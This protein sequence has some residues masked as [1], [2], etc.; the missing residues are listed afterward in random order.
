MIDKSHC[1][2]E[3][4]GFILNCDGC[5]YSEEFQVGNNWGEFI[6]DAKEKGW[7]FKKFDDG[8]WEHYCDV[9]YGNFIDKIRKEK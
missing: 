9:C 7:R 1:G 5:S 4:I 3:I 2:N 6:E 8:N